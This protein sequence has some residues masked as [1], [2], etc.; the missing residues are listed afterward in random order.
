MLPREVC[1]KTLEKCQRKTTGYNRGL[2]CFEHPCHNGNNFV[3]SCRF[4]EGVMANVAIN[5]YFFSNHVQ[6]I[7]P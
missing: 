7:P 5:Q 6:L 2:N 1:N 3:S 4:N